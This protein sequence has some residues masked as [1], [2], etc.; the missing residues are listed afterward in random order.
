MDDWR[1][2]L[3]TGFI[4]AVIGA[5]AT[6]GVDLATKSY[7]AF[8]E[9]TGLASA[10]Q[11]EVA[12]I[13]EMEMRR[14]KTLEPD[15]EGL[16]KPGDPLETGARRWL[17]PEAME[18]LKPIVLDANFD[19]IGSLSDDLPRGVVLF[20]M[21]QERLQIE[22]NILASGKILLASHTERVRLVTEYRETRD[23]IIKLGDELTKDLGVAKK[24]RWIL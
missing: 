8:Q 9:R 15:L 3:W 24:K 19:K 7:E 20:Y 21:L 1:G 23:A 16:T 4:G 10:F 2:K 12:A 6:G 5:L 22:M 18:S 14:I 17:I 11:G 13:K